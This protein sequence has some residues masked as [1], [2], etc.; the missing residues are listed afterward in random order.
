MAM[1]RGLP[2]YVRLPN[3]ETVDALQQAQAG[4]ELVE[5]LTLEDLQGQG[6]GTKDQIQLGTFHQPHGEHGEG[7]DAAVDC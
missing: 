5:H 3:A 7:G 6:I 2:F 1:Q 4:T